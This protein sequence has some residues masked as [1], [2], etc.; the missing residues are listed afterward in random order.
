MFG[1]V[2]YGL[3]LRKLPADEIRRRVEEILAAT[4]LSP[5]ADR[6]PGELSGGQQQR[7]SLAR[8]LV[9]KPEI[10]L[11]DEPLSN[12]DANLRE[13][14]R[15]EIRRLHDEFR[16]TTVYV[17][18]DQ[19]EAMDH[20][21]SH[22]RDERR[23]DRA[24]RLAE[25]IYERP[26]TEFVARFIGGTN[27]L[28]GRRGD[29][30]TVVR[31]D[32]LAIE[33]RSG[34]VAGEGETAVSIRQ[35]DIHLSETK[36]N[37]IDTNTAPATVVRQIYLGSHRDYLVSLADGETVRAFAPVDF[38]VPAGGQVWVRFPPE[39][40]RALA[41]E[42]DVPN[43]AVTAG[44]GR[45]EPHRPT[46]PDIQGGRA[47]RTIG[48]FG[49]G[50]R[51]SCRVGA[52]GAGPGARAHTRSRPSSRRPRKARAG[53]L[54]H[55]TDVAVAERLAG[56]FREKYPEIQVQVERAGSERLSSSASDRIHERHLQCRRDR[57]LGRRALRVFQARGL[58]RAHG[59]RG[60][61]LPLA[62]DR[63][64]PGRQLRRLPRAP[65][66]SRLPHRPDAGADAPKTWTDLLDPKYKTKMVKAHPGYSG[67][68]MTATFALS[69]ALGWEWFEKLG[70]QNV[71]QVQ[72]STEP[73]K[74]LAQ[75]ERA[76]EIDGNEYKRLPSPGR[77]R[78]DQDR[79]SGRGHAPGRRQRGGARRSASSQ[80][81]Q[82]LLQLPVL[83]GGAAAETATSAVFAPSIR[84]W[85]R[86]P[87]APR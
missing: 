37:G 28:K 42:G 4:R 56:L 85:S 77:G 62:G 83:Q 1:N 46:H 33:C 48:S 58:A 8:A 25:D 76:L 16:Y 81:R 27:I 52:G 54:L 64:G 20:G 14:M 47:C 19:S 69:Q 29:G 35:H 17:T 50:A 73:P 7:V 23:P 61:R 10:L 13:E 30:A 6:Y 3:K 49:R 51:R 87:V 60:R 78:S 2:A 36:P 59:P 72:S 21:R 70:G 41:A 12:L 5:L 38:A 18:H 82:A 79:L 55:R 53:G 65:L 71:M 32:G 26:E 31:P 67:T 74:K 11:L 15:F 9:V 34:T 57:D 80:R 75:G 22:R 66:G 63:K 86:R 40:C 45:E 68:V 24:G 39:R 43:V 84:K 44:S